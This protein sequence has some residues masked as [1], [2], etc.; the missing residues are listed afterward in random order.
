MNTYTIVAD[1]HQNVLKI[2]DDVGS[3]NGVVSNKRTF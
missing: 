2:R 3:Q 1:V